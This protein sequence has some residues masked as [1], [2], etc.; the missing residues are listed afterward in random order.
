VKDTDEFWDWQD[1]KLSMR[2]ELHLQDG[3]LIGIIHEKKLEAIM[4]KLMIT[5]GCGSE[6]GRGHKVYGKVMVCAD[7]SVWFIRRQFNLH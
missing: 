6:G 3:T 7:S 2:I 1:I 4:K 5:K